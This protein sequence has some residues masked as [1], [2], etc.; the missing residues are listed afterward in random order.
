LFCSHY[1]PD[2]LDCPH[3]SYKGYGGTC[4]KHSVLFHRTL[5]T[6]MMSDWI[7]RSQPVWSTYT[8]SSVNMWLRPSNHT[9]SAARLTFTLMTSRTSWMT[10]TVSVMNWLVHWL[11]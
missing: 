2:A 4:N 8:E 3:P 9:T 6:G 5:M 11:K 7:Y 10:L 1:V